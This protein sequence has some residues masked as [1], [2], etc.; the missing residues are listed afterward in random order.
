MSLVCALEMAHSVHDALHIVWFK[1]E[2]QRHREC[3][4]Q[5]R[6]TVSAKILPDALRGRCMYGVHTAVTFYPLAQYRVRY[7]WENYILFWPSEKGT[8]VLGKNGES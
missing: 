7:S 5:V 6:A 8:N 1:M 4:H 3:T 2:L